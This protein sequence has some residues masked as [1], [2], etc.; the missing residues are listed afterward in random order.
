MHKISVPIK[1]STINEN[2][3]QKYVELCK[4]ADVE[5]IFLVV[6]SGSFD[7]IEYTVEF[8]NKTA[9]RLSLRGIHRTSHNNMPPYKVAYC[10]KRT[11]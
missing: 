10:W 3:R 8:L 5:R 9:L 6:G 1:T 7:G 4:K 11:A 2:N